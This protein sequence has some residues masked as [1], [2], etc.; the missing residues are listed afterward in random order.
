MSTSDPFSEVTFCQE[1]PSVEVQ[2]T[3]CETPPVV[4]DAKYPPDQLL[5]IT[6]GSAPTK[7]FAGAADQ[8]KPCQ[9]ASTPGVVMDPAETCAEVSDP[10]D[11]AVW[12]GPDWAADV[13]VVGDA[14]GPDW[15]PPT[16][17][18]DANTSAATI[19]I[20]AAAIPTGRARFVLLF[21]VAKA[22]GGVVSVKV[23][24]SFQI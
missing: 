11:R 7:L 2:T 20:A 1:V 6:P 21:A 14:P 17:P 3:P 9:G 23:N 24:Q 4:P 13:L 18:R 5:T 16:S 8:E 19:T 22:G 10:D 12:L 15:G